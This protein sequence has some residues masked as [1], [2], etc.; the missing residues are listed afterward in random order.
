MQCRGA[1]N[2]LKNSGESLAK[3]GGAPERELCQ[4]GEFFNGGLLG[5][6]GASGWNGDS[7]GSFKGCR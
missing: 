3:V 7:F 5:P 2:V 1:L 4:L 6:R